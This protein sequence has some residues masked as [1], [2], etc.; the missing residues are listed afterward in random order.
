MLSLEYAVLA[1]VFLT[2]VASEAGLTWLAII[3]FWDFCQT[4]KDLIQ[5]ATGM[6]SQGIVL[7]A[8]PLLWDCRNKLR[9][10]LGKNKSIP[11]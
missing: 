1:P 2:F 8:G 7:C 4:V 11:K 9:L 3:H 6:C 10:A 5:V